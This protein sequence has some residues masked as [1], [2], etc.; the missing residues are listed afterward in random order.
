VLFRSGTV[1]N[2]KDKL[3]QN[4]ENLKNKLVN[5]QAQKSETTTGQ[6]DKVT[7]NIYPNYTLQERSLNI[8]YFLNK[9]DD[10]FI[11]KL[12]DELDIDCYMHQVI[13]M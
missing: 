12:F 6:I 3:F 13:E 10:G 5:A 1:D 11:R 7:N 2:I 9:Y 8:T 4:I